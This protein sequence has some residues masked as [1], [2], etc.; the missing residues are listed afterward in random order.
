MRSLAQVVLVVRL[1]RLSRQGIESPS[2]PEIPFFFLVPSGERRKRIADPAE[3]SKAGAA[4][5]N[6]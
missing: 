4:T 3:V 1:E 2:S 5:L 6:Y